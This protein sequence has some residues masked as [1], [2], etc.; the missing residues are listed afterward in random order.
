MYCRRFVIF[1][2]GELLVYPLLERKNVKFQ[3]RA[4]SIFEKHRDSLIPEE[5]EFLRK[6]VTPNSERYTPGCKRLGISND[7]YK[8]LASSNTELIIN[9]EDDPDGNPIVD[10]YENGIVLKDGRR[11]EV[12]AIAF[13]T[14]YQVSKIENDFDIIGRDGASFKSIFNS[15]YGPRAYKSVV[16]HRFPNFFSCLGANSGIG[17]NS[18]LLS[19]EIGCD[20]IMEMI[21]LMMVRGYKKVEVKREVEEE[22][23]RMMDE[24]MKEMIWTQDERSWYKLNGTGRVHALFGYNMFTFWRFL[25]KPDVGDYLVEKC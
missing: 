5:Q 6:A 22:Y 21:Y 10:F 8:A 17:S 14:G 20:Y 11:L 18:Y 7:F 16:M 12:D 9:R 2:V 3:K 23:C 13:C 25:R 15:D 4:I 24:R 1:V 19:L